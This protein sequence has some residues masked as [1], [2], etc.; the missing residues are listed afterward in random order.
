MLDITAADRIAIHETIALHGHVADDRDWDRW[1]ELYTD[2]VV[3]DLEDFGSGT[4]RGL[5]ALRKMARD[6]QS[7]PTQ[8]L[9]H[10]V[11]NIVVV[12]EDG[13]RVRARSKGLAV[14]ADGTSGTVVYEDTLRREPQGWRICHRKALARR[15]PA[16]A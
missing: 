4:T 2:D 5:A 13:D 14:N 3:L 10:H 6:T 9:G 12:A 11:T 7:D 16:Q 15:A 1:G 8:P